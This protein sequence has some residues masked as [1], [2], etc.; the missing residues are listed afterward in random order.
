MDTVGLLG[1]LEAE[2]MEVMWQSQRA[3][4]RDVVNQLGRSRPLAYTTV[5]TVMNTLAGKGLLS[6]SS[7]GRANLFTVALTRESFLKLKAEQAVSSVIT[8]FGD[9]AIAQFLEA[10]SRISPKDLKRLRRLMEAT[11]PMTEEG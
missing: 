2:V 4:V 6:R 8:R 1:P 11:A 10:V 3:T 5:M 9:L 7:E